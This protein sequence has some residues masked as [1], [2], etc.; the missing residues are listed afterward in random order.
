MSSFYHIIV[1]FIYS[2]LEFFYFLKK[3]NLILSLCL[4]FI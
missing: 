4:T 3:P 1:E 2:Y